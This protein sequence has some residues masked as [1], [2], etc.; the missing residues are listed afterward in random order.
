MTESTTKVRF[1][2]HEA[3]LVHGARTSNG[4]QIYEV[5][6]KRCWASAVM[7]LMDQ[8]GDPVPGPYTCVVFSQVE[9]VPAK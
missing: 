7:G 1:F 3:L 9:E 4:H 2:G 5:G 8:R 6:G